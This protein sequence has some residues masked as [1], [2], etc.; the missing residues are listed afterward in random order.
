VADRAAAT[1][2]L[3]DSASDL[4]ESW[5]YPVVRFLRG[6]IDE[7][8]LLKRADNGDKRTEA[9]CYLGLDHAIKR[10][11]SE[12]SAYFR[13]VKGHGNPTFVEYTIA[14]A[15]LERLEWAPER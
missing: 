7:S 6:E 14:V 15:E 11:Q 13:W 12:A 10:R 9:R 1:R 8:Q 5:P 3:N 4:N 2:F